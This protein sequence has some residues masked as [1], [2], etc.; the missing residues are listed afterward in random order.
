MASLCLTQGHQLVEGDLK[1]MFDHC[2]QSLPV[3]AQPKFVRILTHMQVTGT[4][5]QQKTDLVKE[6]F[7]PDKCRGDGLYF[8]DFSKRTYSPLTKD[9]YQEVVAGNIKL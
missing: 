1:G 8:Q 3:Y 2:M 6:G 7:D 5:K 9:L 4:F